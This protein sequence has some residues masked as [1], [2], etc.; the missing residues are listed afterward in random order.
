MPLTAPGMPH[1]TP[2]S[3]HSMF[4]THSYMIKEYPEMALR[5]HKNCGRLFNGL[6]PETQRHII[7]VTS[8]MCDT[9]WMRPGYL[10]CYHTPGQ[11]IPRKA[12]HFRLRWTP[13]GTKMN[14]HLSWCTWFTCPGCKRVVSL[15]AK[16]RQSMIGGGAPQ[17]RLHPCCCEH[18]TM[19]K[20]GGTWWGVFQWAKGP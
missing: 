15:H 7:G 4:R 16:I 8:Q 3:M 17:Y 18:G 12:M 14:C 5:A 20:E 9:M 11:Y 1:T 10:Q 13:E 6:P 2:I 19:A